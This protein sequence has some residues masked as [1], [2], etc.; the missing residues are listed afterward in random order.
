M[1][2]SRKEIKERRFLLDW[3]IP[4]LGTMILILIFDVILKEPSR[5]IATSILVMICSLVLLNHIISSKQIKKSYKRKSNREKYY[6]P[7]L[8]IVDM[9]I[10]LIGTVILI[11]L[12]ILIQNLS[13]VVYLAIFM[14][15]F[16]FI[17]L[18]H[19][20]AIIKNRR[21]KTKQ[22]VMKTQI[23]ISNQKEED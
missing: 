8:T 5:V 3:L 2:K 20:I 10:G 18:N 21:I 13:V 12:D 14:I 23:E 16:I 17:L 22:K 19:I 7:D 15:C 4:L 11:V 9:I 6:L 1:I